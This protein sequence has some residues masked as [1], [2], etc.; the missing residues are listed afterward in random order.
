MPRNIFAFGIPVLLIIA[1]LMPFITQVLQGDSW[2]GI[3]HHDI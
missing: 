2:L 1:I 3:E